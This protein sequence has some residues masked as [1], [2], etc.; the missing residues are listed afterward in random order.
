MDPKVKQS[1]DTMVRKL[2]YDE[3]LP[4][5][6]QKRLFLNEDIPCATWSLNN[7]LIMFAHDTSDARGFW[8]W[9]KVGRY[10]A[11]GSKAFHILA[12]VVVAKRKE[13]G[14]S[15]AEAGDD[16][17]KTYMYCRPVPVFRY[18]DTEGRPLEYR[19]NAERLDVQ[20]LPLADVAREMGLEVKAG[21]S[22]EH[23]G[24]YYLGG[25]KIEMCTDDEQTFLHEL[26]HAVDHR[27]EQMSTRQED[28]IVAE[29]SA[30]FLASLYGRRANMAY[31]KQYVTS[32]AGSGHIGLAIGRLLHRVVAIH[33][34][35]TEHRQ[36]TVA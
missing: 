29:L 3:E 8:A 33:Q 11:K 27:L 30:C 5:F 7:Q 6:L 17:E 19:L 23:Y 26:S 24:A 15:E 16:E 36:A 20:A 22:R 32:Y 34:F 14:E 9:Q 18:E 2:I 25:Q 13:N 12:P 1:L 28:E 35:I 21:F 10:V 31:T 4:G